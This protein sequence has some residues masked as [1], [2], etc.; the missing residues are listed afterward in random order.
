MWQFPHHKS[1]LCH[2]MNFFRW[3]NKGGCV[4]RK[5]ELGH[6]HIMPKCPGGISA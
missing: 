6:G 1:Q 3:E 2:H 4:H 5:W